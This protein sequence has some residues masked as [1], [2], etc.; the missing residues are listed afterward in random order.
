MDLDALKR[1]WQQIDRRLERQHALA[2]AQFQE[3]RMRRMQSGLR[4]LYWGQWLQVMLGALCM[5]VATRVWYAHWD[6]LH[7]RVAA[8]IVHGYG[9]AAI[10]CGERILT[11]MGRVD[12]TAPVVAIQRQIAELRRWYVWSG[13]AL[14]LPWWFLWLPVFMVLAAL[15]GV[16]VYARAPRLLVYCAGIGGVGL[17]IMLGLDALARRPGWHRLAGYHEASMVAASLRR[18]QAAI[19]EVQRFSVDGADR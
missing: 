13:N 12:P 3:G 6:V 9:L 15:V 5:V 2:V 11:L 1:T 14:G 16:D 7:L 18:A 8:L 4:A 17:A 19:D 10:L